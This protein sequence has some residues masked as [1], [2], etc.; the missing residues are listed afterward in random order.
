MKPALPTLAVMEAGIADALGD[1]ATAY[2]RQGGAADGHAFLSDMAAVL[3][4]ALRGI[5][6]ER[7]R[8][9]TGSHLPPHRIDALV[10]SALSGK[11]PASPALPEGAAP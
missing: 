10:C 6:F 11:A 5:A 9:Q 8:D 1:Y 7:L 3:V 4:G 2:Q